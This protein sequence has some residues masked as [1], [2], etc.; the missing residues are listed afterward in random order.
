MKIYNEKKLKKRLQ[1]GV[2]VQA[3]NPGI[4]DVEA[5]RS[6][7]AMFPI[8]EKEFKKCCK[9]GVAIHI[10]NPSVGKF[11]A[12]ISLSLRQAWYTEQVQEQSSLGS[13]G[14]KHKIQQRYN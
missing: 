8:C 14:R 1:L 12:D 13:E 2:R 11:E 7:P 9:Q 6:Y 3:L 5:I 10:F 4:R